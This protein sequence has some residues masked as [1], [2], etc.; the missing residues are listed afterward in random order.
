MMKRRVGSSEETVLVRAV[1]DWP[2]WLF[3]HLPFD[4]AVRVVDCFVVEGHKMLL[5]VALAIIYIWS[6]KSK[7]H[8]VDMT[9]KSVE[10][11][12]DALAT[13]FA[14]TASN[15]PVSIQT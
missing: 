10:E 6:K 1:R 11:R 2:S 7:R 4:Y 13:E 5:R 14:E 15:C 12:A 9:S 3:H 8:H